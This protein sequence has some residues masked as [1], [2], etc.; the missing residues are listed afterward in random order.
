VISFQ[1][2]SSGTPSKS[3]DCE[4]LLIVNTDF[5][6]SAGSDWQ[7]AE[8]PARRKNTEE[9][10]NSLIINYRSIIFAKNKILIFWEL[11]P[12]NNYSQYSRI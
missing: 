8:N 6:E 7:K 1:A 11:I 9:I 2:S 12:A 5:E 4:N 3:M 10:K